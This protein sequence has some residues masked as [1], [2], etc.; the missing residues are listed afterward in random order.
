MDKKERIY[1]NLRNEMMEYVKSQYSLTIFIYT[2]TLTI[3]TLLLDLKKDVPIYAPLLANII[4]FPGSL[5]IIGIRK[6]ITLMTVYLTKQENFD[7]ELVKW[8]KEKNGDLSSN[9]SFGIFTKMG[10][11]IKL[12]EFSC[13]SFLC[14]VM[15][16]ISAFQE[17]GG[18]IFLYIISIIIPIIM[19]VF[20]RYEDLLET[21]VGREV[22]D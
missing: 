1:W 17:G 5:R 13:I 6:E 3:L 19:I 12:Y 18:N 8:D 21:E 9:R 15:Y 14:S 20:S 11:R 4:L 22:C 7:E 10:K 16:W 2:A